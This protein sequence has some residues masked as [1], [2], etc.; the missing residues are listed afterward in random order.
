MYASEF[1]IEDELRGEQSLGI[2]FQNIEAS[3]CISRLSTER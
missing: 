3:Q 2:D 1:M